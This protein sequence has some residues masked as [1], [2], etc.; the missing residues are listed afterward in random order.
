MNSSQLFRV[1]QDNTE[2]PLY[3]LS[4]KETFESF[5]AP[6]KTVDKQNMDL[7]IP[8]EE[9]P[10]KATSSTQQTDCVPESTFAGI[11]HQFTKFPQEIQER[12]VEEYIRIYSPH[13]STIKDQAQ[14]PITQDLDEQAKPS[15][16]LDHTIAY[17]FEASLCSLLLVSK[18]WYKMV[19]GYMTRNAVYIDGPFNLQRLLLFEKRQRKDWNSKIPVQEMVIDKPTKVHTFGATSSLITWRS[20]NMDSLATISNESMM[21]IYQNQKELETWNWFYMPG[22]SSVRRSGYNIGGH[23]NC[24]DD[25]SDID[26]RS[27]KDN[28]T[29]K[30]VGSVEGSCDSNNQN[31]N[32]GDGLNND[33][34]NYEPGSFLTHVK[35]LILGPGSSGTHKSD[36]PSSV[37]SLNRGQDTEMAAVYY[38]L[39]GTHLFHKMF[40]RSDNLASLKKLVVSGHIWSN[41]WLFVPRPVDSDFRF[42][43]LTHLTLSLPCAA[44]KGASPLRSLRYFHDHSADRHLCMLLTGRHRTHDGVVIEE[45]S[46][47]LNTLEYLHIRGPGAHCCPQ[48]F[49]ANWKKLNSVIIEL[50]TTAAI[51]EPGTVNLITTIREVFL[52]ELP[53]A[54]VQVN[55]RT[56][57]PWFD[58]HFG[59]Y[60]WRRMKYT[61]PVIELYPGEAL[62]LAHSPDGINVT[63]FSNSNEEHTI[64]QAHPDWLAA[65]DNIQH[66][67]QLHR[68]AAIEYFINRDGVDARTM[69]WEHDHIWITA[70][71]A[72]TEPVPV[73]AGENVVASVGAAPVAP[74][75]S[76]SVSL[77]KGERKEEEEPDYTVLRHATDDEFLRQEHEYLEYIATALKGRATPGYS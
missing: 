23:L 6:L 74:D 21:Q 57:M 7:S 40:G 28:K 18:A 26:D 30:D 25:G 12:V 27:I 32:L 58:S 73:P 63:L 41:P 45:G 56:I 16:L 9:M 5:R 31:L 76:E 13:L 42:P 36:I 29:M 2:D 20:R 66:E 49:L 64:T 34:E 75:Q 35:T 22:S 3:D 54:E 72:T 46:T 33:G 55:L 62:P 68:N 38:R 44:H 14:I 48:I 52:R 4:S 70:E 1:H 59:H 17:E 39:P 43:N 11:F 65:I 67:E 19:A 10:A 50:P 69:V 24:D 61:L 77:A 51:C 47:F 37:S 53:N 71:N 15:H 60:F 8:L